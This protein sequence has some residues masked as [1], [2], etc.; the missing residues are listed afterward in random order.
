MASNLAYLSNL[1]CKEE[2]IY[3]KSKS[4]LDAASGKLRKL[5]ALQSYA[6]TIEQIKPINFLPTASKKL[7]Q[8]APRVY[9]DV[10][11]K[12]PEKKDRPPFEKLVTVIEIWD[13][14]KKKLQLRWHI[15]L[16]NRFDDETYQAGPLFHL[17]AGGHTPQSDRQ[18]ELKVSIPRWPFPPMEL[19][20][21][22]EMIIANFYPDKWKKIKRQKKWLELIHAS[23]QL[24]YPTYFQ[25]IQNCLEHRQSVLEALWATEWD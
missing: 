7:A 5:G 10:A 2:L 14:L 12:S 9:I 17:Q 4:Y 1:L 16:A 13:V 25:R 18:Q 8:I 20:L 15:D 6:Y 3:P 11:I 24:C 19:I 21:T 22:C 23:Q